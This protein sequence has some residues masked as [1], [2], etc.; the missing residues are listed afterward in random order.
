M[1][2]I[3][4]ADL[5]IR[6]RREVVSEVPCIAKWPLVYD[7]AA[8]GNPVHTRRHG[9]DVKRLIPLLLVALVLSIGPVLSACSETNLH[10]I[11]EEPQL[12]EQP[13]A[14][15]PTIWT[16]WFQQRT[17][18]ASD[19]LFVIDDSGSMQDEQDELIANFQGFSENFIG[20]NL[21]YHIGVVRAD[22][23]AGSDQSATWGILEPLPDGTSW[24]DPDT[25]NMAPVFQE[26]ANVGA[27]GA[28]QCEMGLQA[29]MSALTYQTHPGMPNQDFFR[30][31]G[32]L[33]LVIISDEAD[34]GPDPGGPLGMPPWGGG[35]PNEYISWWTNNLKG[36]NDQDK[37]LFTAIV[38]PEGGCGSDD[39]GADEGDGYLQVV[40]EVGGNF[41]SVCEADWAQFLIQ[42]GLESAGLKT[43]F[44]LRRIPIESTL[45][46]TIDGT[47]P[48]GSIWTYDP[49]RNSID[50]PI[51]HI[52]A[53]LAV[54]EATYQLAEDTGGFI[55]SDEPAE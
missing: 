2:L 28:G 44:Q 18:E 46:V 31:D 50:F 52:P 43:S 29:S 23:A 21:D 8:Q 34:H 54:V 42:L 22:L 1:P 17:V 49:V 5:S 40:E 24:I 45:V 33:S 25:D 30:E 55:P 36:P 14:L 16:D 51:E 3:E 11:Y 7:S 35:N 12:H 9:D 26:V 27:N 53:E 41:L 47:E 19:I 6:C 39:D 38:G 20:T 13:D 48:D 37:L 4:M 32:L 15:G 10:T